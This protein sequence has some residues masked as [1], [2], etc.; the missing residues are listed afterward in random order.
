[1]L[2]M[3]ETVVNESQILDFFSLLQFLANCCSLIHI[4]KEFHGITQIRFIQS[5]LN[6]NRMDFVEFIDPTG[7]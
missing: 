7:I 4:S 5:H 1:M 6:I 2:L 3:L